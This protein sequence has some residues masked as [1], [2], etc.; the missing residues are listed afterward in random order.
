MEFEK[1]MT[2]AAVIAT[3]KKRQMVVMKS[4]SAST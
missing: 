2:I 1:K 4:I 3:A